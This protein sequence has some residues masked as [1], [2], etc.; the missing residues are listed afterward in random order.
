VRAIQILNDIELVA[1]V[2]LALVSIREW[3]RRRGEAAGWVAATFGIVG[4]VLLVGR[5]LPR[6]AGGEVAW[7]WPTKVLLALLLLFPYFLYR[8]MASL[9]PPRPWLTHLA[10]TLTGMVVGLTLAL[11][12]FPKPPNRPAWF[13]LYVVAL[14]AQWTF[15][16]VSVAVGLWK[17]GRDEPVMAQRRLRMLAFGSAGLA[18]IMVISGATPADRAHP[19]TIAT[20]ILAL[21]SAVLFY[22]GFAPPKI[23]RQAW[24]QGEDDTLRGAVAR[25]M[26]ARTVEEVAETLIPTLTGLV[27]GKAAAL[28]DERGRIVGSFGL[29]QEL[30]YE[31]EALTTIGD[32][33]RDGEIRRG[34][35]ALGLR[36][37]SLLVWA[38]PFTPYFGADDLGFLR[39]LADLADLALERCDLFARERSFIASASHELRTPL[40]TIAGMAGILT[41][42]WR[43][44]NLDTIE[45]CLEAINRQSVR[46]RDLVANLL[47]LAHIENTTPTLPLCPVSL[48]AAGRSALEVAPPPPGRVV[49]LNIGEAVT[50]FADPRGL[51]RALTNLLVNAYRYGGP[52]VR[53]EAAA[54]EREVLLTVSDNGNGVPPDLVPRLFD[55]FTRGP[56][57]G[58][59]TGSGLGLA[60]TRQLVETFGGRIGYEPGRPRGAKFCV[61]LR[62]VAA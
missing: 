3:R 30:A 38:S 62:K 21:S 45:D 24:R 20:Q 59:I 27:G 61:H 55:P 60:I 51:E 43:Q 56:S 10:P 39:Y 15:L 53:V 42:T 2:A 50:A 5:F 4:G 17:G 46:V 25:L 44:M 49:D 37:G 14:V 32:S 18:L 1:F 54:L 12:Y 23:L 29:S 7:F 47:D 13:E 8:F 16:S 11:P 41:D 22:L 31:V 48:A 52:L 36:R 33:L 28:T 26:T 34:L 58:S 57:T 9:R 6:T 19:L 35:F 40:T